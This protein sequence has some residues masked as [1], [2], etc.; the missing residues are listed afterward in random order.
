MK[1]ELIVIVEKNKLVSVLNTPINFESFMNINKYT[2][3]ESADAY[4]P[5]REFY[6]YPKTE[7]YLIK[8]GYYVIK[9]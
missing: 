2:L 8:C 6:Q 4:E 7:K 1:N 3:E 9:L 5:F